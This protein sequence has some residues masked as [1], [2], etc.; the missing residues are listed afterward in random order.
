MQTIGEGEDESQRPSYDGDSQQLADPRFE[1]TEDLSLRLSDSDISD[2]EPDHDREQRTQGTRNTTEQPV[3]KDDVSSLEKQLEERASSLQKERSQIDE[4]FSNIERRQ[5]EV[6]ERNLLLVQKRKDFEA[7]L[8]KKEADARERMQK[9]LRDEMYAK[10]VNLL[11]QMEEETIA[12]QRLAKQK[13]KEIA[14]REFELQQEEERWE[15]E[16][17]EMEQG[18][19]NRLQREYEKERQGREI[20]G[21]ARPKVLKQEGKDMVEQQYDTDLQGRAPSQTASKGYRGC[22][23]QDHHYSE[24]SKQD[25]K[26][27][28]PSAIESGFYSEPQTRDFD[29]GGMHMLKPV[30]MGCKKPT[31]QLEERVDKSVLKGR[32]TADSLQ[33]EQGTCCRKTM[34]SKTQEFTQQQERKE[35]QEIQ[36]E[37][38]VS[39]NTPVLDSF[40][41]KPPFICIFS[42]VKPRLRNESSFEDWK[43]EVDSLMATKVYSD[44]ALTQAIRKSLRVPAKRA[45]LPLGPTATPREIVNCLQSSYGYVASRD[46]VIEE[47]YTAEQ[48]QDESV[49]D[50]GIRL[51]EILQ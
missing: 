4:L 24:S 37:K 34:E 35:P 51:E 39:E 30:D 18:C 47:F 29:R 41:T 32:Q 12:K 25:T 10:G 21:G 42:G 9:A 2:E 13:E 33:E 28:A 20:S 5:A 3:P 40:N 31:G 22:S 44:I 11:Q 36:R 48:G 1:D 15:I 27:R 19:I 45:L 8:Q 38:L 43:L 6:E 23:M 14:Q 46:A 50:W 7:Q 26:Y 16:K 17:Q 49:S